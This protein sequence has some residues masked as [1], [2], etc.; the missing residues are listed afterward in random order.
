[1]AS[2]CYI[3]CLEDP[4]VPEPDVGDESDVEGPADGEE[5]AEAEAAE[6]DEGKNKILPLFRSRHGHCRIVL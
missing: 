3:A 2:G 5:E 6:P 4:L 1:M